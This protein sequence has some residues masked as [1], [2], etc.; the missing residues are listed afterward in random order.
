MNNVGSQL[1]PALNTYLVTLN[2]ITASVSTTCLDHFLSLNNLLLSPASLTAFISYNSN[3]DSG[4]TMDSD[5][6]LTGKLASCPVRVCLT[7]MDRPQEWTRITL[8]SLSKPC[9]MTN[10]MQLNGQL[11]DR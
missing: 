3:T 11:D 6:I 5:Q 1:K 10:F 4:V 2:L 9:Q 8:T 7:E